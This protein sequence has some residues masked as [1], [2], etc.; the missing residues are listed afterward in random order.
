[1]VPCESAAF[2]RMP[3]F[4]IVAARSGPC[5]I[6]RAS[7][8]A[9]CASASKSSTG[10]LFVAMVK[11]LRR[12]ESRC[13]SSSRL[14]GSEGGFPHGTRKV[15]SLARSSGYTLQISRE[16]G[17]GQTRKTFRVY[18]GACATVGSAMQRPSDIQISPLRWQAADALRRARKRPVGHD[19]NNLRQLASGLLWLDKRNLQATVQDRVTAFLALIDF[20]S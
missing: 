11:K 9:A 18:R 1:M 6:A 17:A 7:S 14:S 4:F 3:A 20:R 5:D 2:R 19:R 8:S 10:R 12:S 13:L 16:S 15:S